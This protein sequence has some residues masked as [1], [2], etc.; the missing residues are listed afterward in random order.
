MPNSHPSYFQVPVVNSNFNFPK[1]VTMPKTRWSS[2]TKFGSGI[3][4]ITS[5]FAGSTFTPSDDIMCT[6]NTV[7]IT[8][9]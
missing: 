2:F 5:T 3:F 9:V 4:V 6:G 8:P 7:D 1:H